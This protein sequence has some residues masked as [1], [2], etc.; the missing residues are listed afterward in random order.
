MFAEM[1]KLEKQ[2]K[3]MIFRPERE[4]CDLFATDRSLLDESYN[5]GF[6]YAK[7]RMNDLKAFLEI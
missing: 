2:G 4:V 3:V 1:E 5:M 6:D 7:H